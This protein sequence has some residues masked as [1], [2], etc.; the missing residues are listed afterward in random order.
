[1]YED[2]Y[3]YINLLDH[4]TSDLFSPTLTTSPFILSNHSGF[5]PQVLSSFYLF[6][7]EIKSFASLLSSFV[8]H[9]L[10]GY[11]NPFF[12]KPSFRT[13]YL[14]NNIRS[15]HLNKTQPLDYILSFHSF[16]D[17]LHKPLYANMK[18]SFIVAALAS[19]VSATVCIHLSISTFRGRH[20]NPMYRAS[21]MLTPSLPPGT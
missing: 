7:W 8:S 17:I 19:T 13:S 20:T 9:P 6:H 2:D 11:H 4:S 14:N 5:L 12:S 1:M 10:S 16:F 15:T 18:N 21:G 3:T